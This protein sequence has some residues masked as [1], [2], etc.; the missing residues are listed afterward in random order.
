LR[1][2]SDERGELSQVSQ[3]S[4]SQKPKG[5]MNHSTRAVLALLD[6]ESEA[7]TRKA[8]DSSS[9]EGEV[10]RIYPGYQGANLG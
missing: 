9:A 10:S 5:A 6:G 2:K 7:L 3:L 1:H 8:I 4:L